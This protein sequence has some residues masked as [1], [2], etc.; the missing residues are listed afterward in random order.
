VH[1]WNAVEP[2]RLAGDAG[3]LRA[4]AGLAQRVRSQGDEGEAR[5]AERLLDTLRDA[6]EHGD[7]L[8]P[9]TEQLDAEVY[10]GGEMIDSGEMTAGAD[11][12]G[13]TEQRA[14]RIGNLVWLALIVVIILFNVLGQLRDGG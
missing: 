3:R 6:V 13:E 11:M 2:A 9:A 14:S 5:E 7:G 12:E 10:A 4:I 8:A 1:L